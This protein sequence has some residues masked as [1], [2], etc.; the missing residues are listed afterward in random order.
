MK[1][2][3]LQRYQRIIAG[4]FRDLIFIEMENLQRS[5]VVHLMM[6]QLEKIDCDLDVKRLL[7]F[8]LDNELIYDNGTYKGEPIYSRYKAVER[9]DFG[10]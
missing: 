3:S 9:K 6:Q 4:L 7:D 2:Q 10:F 1:D 8:M 5:L